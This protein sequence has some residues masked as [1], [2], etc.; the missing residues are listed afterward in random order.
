MVYSGY[1]CIC[2]ML[3]SDRILETCGTVALSPLGAWVRREL[4]SSAFGGNDNVCSI[5]AK[6]QPKSGS[7]TCRPSATSAE[8]CSGHTHPAARVARTW[9]CLGLRD[10]FASFFSPR[11]H[12]FP[13]FLE[14]CA[15][16]VN[17]CIPPAHL[18]RNRH[19]CSY[20]CM[21]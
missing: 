18:S 20:I 13:S 7:V 6:Q 17:L 15:C 10:S 19:I 5:E 4:S 16:P 8:E 9:R 14:I 12:S 21:C 1:T 3:G 2:D 11:A